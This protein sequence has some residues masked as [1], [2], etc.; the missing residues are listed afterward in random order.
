[1]WGCC[2]MDDHAYSRCVARAAAHV[3]GGRGSCAAIALLMARVPRWRRI[4][5]VR[6]AFD[7]LAM[8]SRLTGRVLADIA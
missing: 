7:R 2:L 3:R 6:H 4:S 8:A 5:P 1:M